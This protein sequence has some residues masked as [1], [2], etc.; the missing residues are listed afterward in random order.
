MNE[1]IKRTLIN[2]MK[3]VGVDVGYAEYAQ[4][5]SWLENLIKRNS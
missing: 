2:I 5:Q 3:F 1:D 4:L